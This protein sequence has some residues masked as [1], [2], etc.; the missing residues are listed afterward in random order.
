MCG[1]AA[2]TLCACGAEMRLL[3]DCACLR[4]C[5]RAHARL[6][7]AAA[8]AALAAARDGLTR[9]LVRHTGC[10]CC[11]AV[12]ADSRLPSRCVRRTH[13]LLAAPLRRGATVRRIRRRNLSSRWLSYLGGLRILSQHS[14]RRGKRSILSWFGIKHGF[15]RLWQ[16]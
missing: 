15:S 13:T 2:T 16:C 12:A 4:R 7:C 9:C 1:A 8:T 14:E 6:W 11:A 3:V 10:C 5:W